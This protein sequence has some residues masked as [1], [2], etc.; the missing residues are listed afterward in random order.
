MALDTG[1]DALRPLRVFDRQFFVDAPN[2][3]CRNELQLPRKGP[4][5]PGAVPEKA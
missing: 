5:F 3:Q 1:F 4:L 2:V